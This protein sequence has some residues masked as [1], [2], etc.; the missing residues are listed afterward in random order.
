MCKASGPRACRPPA[1]AAYSTSH[2]ACTTA[3][4]LPAAAQKMQLQA[5]QCH[6]GHYSHENSEAAAAAALCFCCPLLRRLIG[7]RCQ[8]LYEECL[9]AGGMGGER[10]LRLSPA[11]QLCLQAS[12]C[13]QCKLGQDPALKQTSN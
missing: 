5:H 7:T 6:S 8:R 10:C 11:T 3:R 13:V 9:P 1:S 4:E 2:S 12:R